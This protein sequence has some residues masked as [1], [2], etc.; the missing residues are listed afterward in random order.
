MTYCR[1]RE[2]FDYAHQSAKARTDHTQDLE[3]YLRMSQA[4]CLKVVLT[5]KEQRGVVDSRHRC[6]VVP[7][8]E[9]WKFGDRTARPINTED[10]FA[11][12]GRTLENP[13]MARFDDI[14]SGARLA[15]AEHALASRIIARHS[16]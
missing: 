10:L 12:I 16:T 7:T 4:Q 3:R 1:E 15:F 13:H 5:D 9:D 8:I 14:Q 2:F 11:S 6:G